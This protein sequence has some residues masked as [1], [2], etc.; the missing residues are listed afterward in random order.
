MTKARI[1]YRAFAADDTRGTALFRDVEWPQ[2]P[3]VGDIVDSGANPDPEQ[4]THVESV[5]WG[6]DGAA[7][8]YLGEIRLPDGILLEDYVAERVQKGWTSDPS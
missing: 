5:T 4:R 7:G 2:I 8:I 3:G 1:Q 6:I